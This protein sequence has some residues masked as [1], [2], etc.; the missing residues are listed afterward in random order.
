MQNI[1]VLWFSLW[2]IFLILCRLPIFSEPHNPCTFK[3]AIQSAITFLAEE[4]KLSKAL[5]DGNLVSPID[6]MMFWKQYSISA[7]Y[8][9]YIPK[10]LEM[11]SFFI[12]FQLFMKK[13]T[14]VIWMNHFLELIQKIIWRLLI[15]ALLYFLN[16][17]FSYFL[18][19]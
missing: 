4:L 8:F 11:M 15:I 3:D 14:P 7:K 9:F 13:W 6:L 10:I 1:T 16:H 17:H 18:I 5:I 19:T 2:L 12:K